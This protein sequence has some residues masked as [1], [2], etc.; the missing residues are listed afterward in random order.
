LSK[1]IALGKGVILEALTVTTGNVAAVCAMAWLQSRHSAGTAS[2]M[3]WAK[4]WALGDDMDIS[5]DDKK[6]GLNN[7]RVGFHATYLTK[8]A[9]VL[10]Q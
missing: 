10:M 6:W 8:Q 7:E 9:L 5:W 2:V 4:G 1:G 3:A